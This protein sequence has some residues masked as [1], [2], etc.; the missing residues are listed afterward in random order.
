MPNSSLGV[1]GRDASSG[2]R[3]SVSSAPPPEAAAPRA[4]FA[5]LEDR[6]G[7]LLLFMPQRNHIGVAASWTDDLHVAVSTGKYKLRST[8]SVQTAFALIYSLV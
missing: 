3:R 5:S 6:G 1:G 2:T 7:G 4:C 8:T